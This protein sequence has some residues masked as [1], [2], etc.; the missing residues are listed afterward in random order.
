M[1]DA[2]LSVRSSD[3][4]TDDCLRLDGQ[5]LRE[6]LEDASWA[7]LAACLADRQADAAATQPD[8]PLVLFT[9]EGRTLEA[10][11]RPRPDGVAIEL[12]DV[13]R[14]VEDADRFAR[15]ALQLHR[16]NRDLLTLFDAT[17][18]LGETLDVGAL[19]Q[20]TASVLGDYLRPTAVSVSAADQ[21]GHWGG[22]TGEV[23]DGA[24]VHVRELATARGRLGT[25][26]WWRA[27]DLTVDETRVV[28]VVL[29]K[30]AVSIDHAL[31]LAPPPQTDDRDELGLLT[32]T[33]ARR[34]MAGFVRPF[35]VALVAPPR[36]HAEGIG[37][38]AE[39]LPSGRAGD[40]RARWGPDRVLVALAGADV[41][42]LRRW[43]DRLGTAPGGEAWRTGVA[44]AEGDVD[45]AIDRAAS[46]LDDH[47]PDVV[48]DMGGRARRSGDG[49]RG[50][51]EARTPGVRG[52][53]A[54]GRS[55]QGR[56][57][58]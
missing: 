27:R 2:V 9:R 52:R 49:D 41:R 40:V 15:M 11:L 4:A 30:A 14:H 53:S 37:A 29:R 28:E 57:V 50:Q 33:A 26:M 18:A 56:E 43:L 47:H 55:A 31:L 1:T 54:R 22:P 32:A 44:L 42:Q 34:A 12:H 38:L 24:D 35:A 21:H 19:V 46:A 45:G 6:L 10:A 13:T 3:P 39:A 16:R 8:S 36:E 25:V 5:H 20:T 58:P 48:V 23:E 17:T 51:G 7:A